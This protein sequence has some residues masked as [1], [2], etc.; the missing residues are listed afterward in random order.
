MARNQLVSLVLVP[1]A[2]TV[3][4]GGG[5]MIQIPA[6]AIQI[7]T[8]VVVIGLKIAWMLTPEPVK[9]VVKMG[10]EELVKEVAKKATG[11]S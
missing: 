10:A 1:V 5:A 4:L 2:G 6:L 7:P 9:E 8:I 11:M 3:I